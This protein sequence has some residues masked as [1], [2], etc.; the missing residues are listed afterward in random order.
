[1]RIAHIN[2]T[3]ELVCEMFDIGIRER[4]LEC[5]SSKSIEEFI[6]KHGPLETYDGLAL[7]ISPLEI[8]RYHKIFEMRKPIVLLVYQDE[9]ITIEDKFPIFSYHSFD[10]IA[11]YF[12]RW[13]SNNTGGNIKS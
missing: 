5:S 10:K 3:D 7:H 12:K 4:G 9:D 6:R 1:M 8:S 11:E 13:S 2:H